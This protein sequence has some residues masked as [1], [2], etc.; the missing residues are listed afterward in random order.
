MNHKLAWVWF[1]GLQVVGVENLELLYR[2]KFIHLY[3]T[4][5]V[6]ISRHI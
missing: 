4:E 6:Y 1:H 5:Y 2:L 3:E